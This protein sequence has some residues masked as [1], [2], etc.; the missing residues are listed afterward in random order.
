MTVSGSSSPLREAIHVLN[1]GGLFIL[2][3]NG[4]TPSGFHA[5]CYGIPRTK[6]ETENYFNN[7]VI[8]AYTVTADK[9]NNWTDA[10]QIFGIH[11]CTCDLTN[12]AWMILHSTGG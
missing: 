4:I 12:R 7:R 11:E 2:E 3:T 5:G 8:A 1:G 6:T 9:R 10:I